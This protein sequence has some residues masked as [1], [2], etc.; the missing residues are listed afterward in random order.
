MVSTHRMALPSKSVT[1]PSRS[2]KP[3]YAI[4]GVAPEVTP[5]RQFGKWRWWDAFELIG[6]G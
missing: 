1:A 4:D 3:K 5:A 2:E 6:K